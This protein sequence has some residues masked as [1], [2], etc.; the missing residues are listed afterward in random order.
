MTQSAC[1]VSKLSLEFSSKTLFKNLQ[2]NL[3]KQQLSACIGRNGLGKSL[4][5]QI[6]HFQSVH[7][8]PYEGEVSWQMPHA[9][10]SQFSRLQADTIANALGV[11]PLY[12]AFQRIESG[13]GRFEDFEMTEH[14][15]HLPLLWQQQLLKAN[16]PTQL[17][18]PISCLSEGQKTK[19]AL[20]ALFVKTDHYLLLDEPSNHLDYA[21]RLW[22]IDCLKAHSSGALIVTHDRALLQH[23]AHIYALN[24]HGMSSFCGSYT[25]YTQQLNLQNSA[26][27]RHVLQQKRDLKQL[28]RQ[29]HEIKVKTQKRVQQGQQLRCS[30]SQAKVLL[31]FKKE[32]AGQSLSTIQTQQKKQLEEKKSRILNTQKQLEQFKNQQFYLNHHA[33]KS[34]E[35]LRVNNFKLPQTKH[36]PIHF[37]LMSGEKIHLRGSN[38]IGKSR[39]LSFLNQYNAQLNSDIYL[40]VSTLFLD[41]NFSQLKSE[42]SVLDNLAKFNPKISSTEWRNQLGQLRIRGDKSELPIQCLSGGERL[43]VA[44]LG[45]SFYPVNIE[46]LLLDEPENHLDIE[47][48]DLLAN[49]IKNYSGAVILVSHD[50]E[51]VQACGI[52]NYVEIEDSKE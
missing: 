20:C 22:L 47:S 25:D 42:L 44:L 18:Y 39:F 31:D 21:S 52:Q 38:G 45:L 8:I 3:A 33:S 51:F 14:Q 27:E 4:I 29:Q 17:D 34:G 26:L 15:W 41:Q 50:A 19:L 1:I 28:K 16:L 30:K 48:R 5:L 9:Y 13:I 32:Q 23:A 11:D 12:Q 35:I 43:K 7:D 10:L 2:L 40:C 49:A 36:K 6:L 37:G 24:E 46:L